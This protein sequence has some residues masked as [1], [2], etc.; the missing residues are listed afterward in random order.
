MSPSSAA[1]FPAR[2]AENVLARAINR[3]R[4]S[5]GHQ[6]FMAPTAH[7]AVLSVWHALHALGMPNATV[8]S[9]AGTVSV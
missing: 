5:S 2:A 1:G 6:F 9:G 7:V 3:P 8:F 4:R